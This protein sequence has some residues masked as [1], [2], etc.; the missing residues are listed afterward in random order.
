MARASFAPALD[1]AG[2]PIASYYLNSAFFK[3]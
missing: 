3:M 1:A 2:T